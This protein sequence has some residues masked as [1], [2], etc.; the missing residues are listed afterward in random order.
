MNIQL[1]QALADDLIAHAELAE[2]QRR[3]SRQLAID[4]RPV[5]TDP[6]SEEAS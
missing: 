3:I 5:R 6:P 4:P 2:A 1:L